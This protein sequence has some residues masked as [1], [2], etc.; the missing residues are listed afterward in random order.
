MVIF[1]VA[2]VE[3]SVDLLGSGYHVRGETDGAYVNRSIH[4]NGA[5]VLFL[6]FLAGLLVVVAVL[7]VF[8]WS[9]RVTQSTQFV[10]DNKSIYVEKNTPKQFG[11]CV[12]FI[13]I[14]GCQPVFSLFF[15]SFSASRSTHT[16]SIDSDSRINIEIFDHGFL[17][18]LPF[19]RFDHLCTIA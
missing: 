18:F 9:D 15:F 3:I 13:N 10:N 11:E 14:V 17:F 19:G 4:A 5:G 6:V 1:V 16:V 2:I 7:G 12:D 8:Y